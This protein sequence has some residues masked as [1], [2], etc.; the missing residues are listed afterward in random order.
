MPSPTWPWIN[1]VVH[2][3]RGEEKRAAATQASGRIRMSGA[4]LG[5]G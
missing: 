3:I 4:E 5:R 1:A 2:V